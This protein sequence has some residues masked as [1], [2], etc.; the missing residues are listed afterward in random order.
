ME[1]RCVRGRLEAP[2]HAAA[3]RAAATT[4]MTSV[5]GRWRVV[6]RGA[7]VAMRMRVNRNVCARSAITSS[8]RPPTPPLAGGWR[9]FG[10]RLDLVLVLLDE[11]VEVLERRVQRSSGLGAARG[12]EL[13]VEVAID[14]EHVAHLVG[15]REAVAAVFVG[16]G[17]VVVRGR[18][19]DPL[20]QLLAHL[21][22]GER[23]AVDADGLADVLRAGLEDAVSGLADVLGGDARHLL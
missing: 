18:D 23:L 10:R 2:P 17:G 16:L 12:E 21:L 19:A 7:R 20:G 4:T 13:L 8:H 5:G 14:L 1:R 9:R 6:G 3:T 15:A 11:G 22:D